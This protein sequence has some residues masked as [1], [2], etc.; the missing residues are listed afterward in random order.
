M[1]SHAT[2][3]GKSGYTY[4]AILMIINPAINPRKAPNID[5][6]IDSNRNTSLILD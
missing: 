4:K 3:M 6:N 2:A 5:R 1:Y